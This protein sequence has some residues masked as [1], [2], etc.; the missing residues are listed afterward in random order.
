MKLI[1]EVEKYRELYNPEFM[2][3]KDDS[4]EVTCWDAAAMA[5][6]ATGKTMLCFYTLLVCLPVQCI[7][8]F[9]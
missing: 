5:T 8:Y 3:Y 2:L 6:G 7:F 9:P 4:K 1:L